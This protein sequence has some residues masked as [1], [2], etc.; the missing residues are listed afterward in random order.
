MLQDDDTKKTKKRDEGPPQTFMQFL[1]L[2]KE[3][4]ANSQPGFKAGK[5]NKGHNN[6]AVVHTHLSS[7]EKE[8]VQTFIPST[9]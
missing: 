2:Q 8:K 3:N 7:E 5:R 1:A 4:N 6:Q 9:F